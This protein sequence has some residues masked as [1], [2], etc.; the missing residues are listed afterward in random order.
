MA[1]FEEHC[2]DC[3]R[4]LGNRCE[5]V[6]RWMDEDFKKFGPLHR[7][8]KHHTRGVKEAEEL[9]GELGRKAALVHILK[10]CGHIPTTRQ[11][12]DQ[13]VDSLGM[14]PGKFLGHWE[15]DTFVRAAQAVIRFDALRGNH[16]P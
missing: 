4:I 16:A 5:E 11:W 3:E 14:Q 1:S 10:D 13:E 2:Q 9:F 6:N 15:G 8:S 7:F 12:R